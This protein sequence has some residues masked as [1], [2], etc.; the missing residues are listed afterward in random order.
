M[1]WLRGCHISNLQG[2]RWRDGYHVR[3]LLHLRKQQL[4]DYLHERNVPWLEDSSNQ[5]DKYFR[6]RVRKHLIPLLQ[7]LTDEGLDGRLASLSEQSDQVREI[8]DTYSH[9]HS[10]DEEI[11]LED[12]VS[13]H[14]PR[15][16]FT[17]ETNLNIGGKYLW[18]CC[19]SHYRKWRS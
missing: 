18:H 11:D 14:E 15:P 10:W 6:N 2:M 5:T 19:R 17:N 16:F 12:W 1:K 8:L 9:P 7:E 4:I 3:P 13:I